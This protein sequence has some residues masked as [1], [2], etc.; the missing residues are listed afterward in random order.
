M[1]RLAAL[2]EKI[3]QPGRPRLVCNGFACWVVHGQELASTFFQSLSEA[4]GWSLVEEP[5]QALWFF[6]NISVLFGLIRL[7]NWSRLHAASTALIVFDASLVVDE[8][9][10]QSIN[11]KPE[12]TGISFDFPKRMLI[13]VNARLRDQGRSLPG[14][15]F[16]QTASTD[17]LPGEWFDLGASDQLTPTVNLQWLGLIRPLGPREDKQTGKGWRAHF[18]RLEPIL[19]KNKVAYLQ[20]EDL[21]L[22]LRISSLEKMRSVLFD[23]LALLEDNQQ[24][25]WPCVYLFVESTDLSFAPDLPRR[26]RHIWE[27]LEPNAVHAPLVTVF[28]LADS[29]IQAVD[30]R[31]SLKNTKITDLFQVVLLSRGS[32]RVHGTLNIF[33]P[34]S[35]VVGGRR[36]CF[37]CG[38][39]SHGPS[40]CPSKRLFPT[41]LQVSALA[42]VARMDLMEMPA[43][44]ERLEKALGEDPLQTLPDLLEDRTPEAIV[45]Q[46]V[47][48]VSVHLQLRMAQMVW[49]A[50]GKD[51]PRGIEDSGGAVDESVVQALES[52]RTGNPDRALERL[53]QALMRARRNYQPRVLLGF[54]SMERDEP[55]RA[56]EFWDE[57]LSLAYTSLQRSYILLLL[58]RLREVAGDHTDAVRFY[59]RAHRESPRFFA[60]KYRQ[61]VCML[62]SGFIN[63]ALGFFR[64]IVSQDPDIFSMLLLDPELESGRTH[65]HAMLW[66]LWSDAQSKKE[67]IVGSVQNINE[68]LRQWL[69]ENH[70][71]YKTFYDRIQTLSS[72]VGINNYVAFSK[73]ING[74]IAVKNDIQERVKKDIEE[75]YQ[76]R[77]SILERLHQIH[78][79][80]SWFPFPSMLSKFTKV[81]NKCA[82]DLDLVNQLDL[83]VPEKFHQGHEALERAAEGLDFL[84]RQL[85]WLQGVRNGAL[86]LLLAGRYLLVFELVALLV[87]AAVAFGLALLVPPGTALGQLIH[88][89]RWQVLNVCILIFSFVAVV[90]TALR[91]SSRFE[92]YRDAVLRGK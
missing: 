56:A 74:A 24:A 16:K 87:A 78:R 2:L 64:E 5:Q 10:S 6:P 21:A 86:F 72:Y 19:S 58:G 75:M 77:E 52:L 26:I 49:R 32:S 9:L 29:R 47:F 11:I 40:Q 17:G 12:F 92:T 13:R 63:E 73:I 45:A 7:H 80:A 25:L 3:P 36:P 66:D 54:L 18:E 69:P 30:C 59:S 20:G 84:E 68:L 62:K 48:D 27:Q 4:G 79:E 60:A 38:M 82:S 83:H 15:A 55:K 22:V 46:A 51:W 90:L 89:D 53:D 31:Y 57:A 39:R 85:L 34:A 41:N 35:L 76:K 43:I 28:Q 1:P 33:L 44:M 91:A 61:S 88:A 71:A 67:D 50:R 8:N 23:I 37:Y 81:F 42:R 14:V 65:L 70:P